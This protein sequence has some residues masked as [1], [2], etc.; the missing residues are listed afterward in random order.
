MY[1]MMVELCAYKEN[2]SW[3]YKGSIYNWLQVHVI[4]VVQGE[5]T[6]WQKLRLSV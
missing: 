2:K 4:L 6:W 5:E 3:F 1:R